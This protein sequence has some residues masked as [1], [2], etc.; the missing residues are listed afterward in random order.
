VQTVFRS[1]ALHRL[2]LQDREDIA[3]ELLSAVAL[4]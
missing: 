2:G 3:Q 1:V 4:P